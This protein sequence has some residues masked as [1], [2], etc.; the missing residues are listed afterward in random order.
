MARSGLKLRSNR[1]DLGTE[2]LIVDELWPDG[3]WH[4]VT[5]F[6]S[7]GVYKWDFH[8]LKLKV[9]F[10]GPHYPAAPHAKKSSE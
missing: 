4:F 9:V 2:A 10:I 1:H 7:I 8:G 6:E 3:T 5:K